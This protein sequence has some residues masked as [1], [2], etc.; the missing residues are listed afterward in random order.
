VAKLQSPVSLAR[1]VAHAATA[2]LL[3]LPLPAYAQTV[4]ADFRGCDG[5]GTCR[6]RVAAPH[7]PDQTELLVRPDGIPRPTGDAEMARRLRDRL[8]A[9]LSNMI[10]QVKCIELHALRELDDDTFAAKVTV[11]GV[12]VALDPII[13]EMRK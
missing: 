2:L 4:E 13:L 8:N 12:D 1:F 7:P 6:F 5:S 10:H 3:T 9:L 11:H